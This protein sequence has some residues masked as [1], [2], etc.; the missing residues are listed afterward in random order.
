MKKIFNLTVFGIFILIVAGFYSCSKDQTI[1]VNPL[2]LTE[3]EFIKQKTAQ[4]EAKGKEIFIEQLSLE[5]LN[6]I[7][8]DHHLPEFSQNDLKEAKQTLETRSCSYSCA[9]WVALGDNDGSGTLGV[10]DVIDLRNE[11]CRLGG[12]E[13]SCEAG[14]SNLNSCS[15]SNCPL[16]QFVDNAALSYLSNG[17]ELFIL[18]IDDLTAMQERIL[19]IICC[20]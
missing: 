15:G 2:K 16:S 10:G 17:T 12:V 4:W 19:G 20:Y 13:P 8:R 11:L 3:E 5:E 18:D 6:K 7:M 1:D 14:T 9:T